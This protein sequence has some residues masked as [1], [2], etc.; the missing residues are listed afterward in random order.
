[1]PAVNPRRECRCSEAR[2]PAGRF[3]EEALGAQ[4][5]KALAFLALPLG[6]SHLYSAGRSWQGWALVS[7]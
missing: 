2:T 5:F 4:P 7:E 6:A 1:M 3:Q